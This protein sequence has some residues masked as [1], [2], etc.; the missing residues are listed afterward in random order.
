MIVTR[1]LS[2]VSLGKAHEYSAR[3]QAAGS[4]FKGPEVVVNNVPEDLDVDSE[5]R[6]NQDVAQSSDLPPLDA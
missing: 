1:R 4:L 2:Q 6:V 3:Q 5:V